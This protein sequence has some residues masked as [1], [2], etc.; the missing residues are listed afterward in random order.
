MIGPSY[1]RTPQHDVAMERKAPMEPVDSAPAG[2][3]PGGGGSPVRARE[4]FS[5]AGLRH[6]ERLERWEAHNAR[7]LVGL[8]CRTLD[9]SPLDAR[10]VNL[11]VASLRFAHVTATRHTVE[12]SH[13]RITRNATEGVALYFTLAGESFFYHSDGIHLLRPGRLLICDADRPFLR[14]F[15]SGLRE[16]VLIVPRERLRG[17]LG[18]TPE[19]RAPKVVEFGDAA[20]ADPAAVSLARLVDETLSDPALRLDL[21]T[22]S[23]SLSLVR[24]ILTPGAARG[25]AGLHRNA[26]AFIDRHFADRSLAV[27]DVAAAC[28]V[29]AR[30]LGRVFAGHGDDG[31]ARTITDRR[32]S[33]ASEALSRQPGRPVGEI[34]LACGFGSH[35]QFA[36][37]FRARFGMAPGEVR[38]RA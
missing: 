13:R 17:A 10:E 27:G 19:L 3:E 15:A 26:L 37:V 38:A 33:A 12:R 20:T 2:T 34:A 36:R 16:L 9:G 14:G 6:R 7:A 21:V 35:S 29:S 24:E 31:I 18:E 28:G 22:E 11:Q 5:T 23:S 25:A 8:E 30:H 1:D 4:E 32:L